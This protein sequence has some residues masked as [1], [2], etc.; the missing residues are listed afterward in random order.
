MQ[1]WESSARL[2]AL[3]VLPSSMRFTASEEALLAHSRVFRSASS[4]HSKKENPSLLLKPWGFFRKAFIAVSSPWTNSWSLATTSFPFSPNNDS[5]RSSRGLYCTRARS[6]CVSNNL[7]SS[8]VGK[9][10]SWPLQTTVRLET[11]TRRNP[12]R[13]RGH[14]YSF[15]TH[16]H[17][18]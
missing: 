3:A 8:S 9:F 14:G 7:I 17:R 16:L 18:R 15:E 6:V 4:I 10:V 5:S 2:R 11:R 1:L 12:H 13:N